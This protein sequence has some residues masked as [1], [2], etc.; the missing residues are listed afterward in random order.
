MQKQFIIVAAT[1]WV[2]LLVVSCGR[3]WDE[4]AHLIDEDIIKTSS[5]LEVPDSLIATPTAMAVLGGDLYWIEDKDDR[6]LRSFDLSSHLAE[7]K[8][9]RKGRADNEL[10]YPHQLLTIPEDHKVGVFDPFL[11]K[12]YLY[13]EDSD[14][15]QP[16]DTVGVAG[17]ASVAHCADGVCG[18]LMQSDKR[19]GVKS[20]GLPAKEFG[21]FDELEIP[22]KSVWSILQGPVVSNGGLMAAFSSYAADYQIIDLEKETVVNGALLEPPVLKMIN[23]AAAM[24]PESKVGF[25]SITCDKDCIYALYDGKTISSYKADSR[26]YGDTIY[27]ISWDGKILGKYLSSSPISVITLDGDKLY[28]SALVDDSYRFGSYKIT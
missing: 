22:A 26:L 11:Q 19:F 24:G 5:F 1:L 6:P 18:V 21:G 15:L 4:K 25:V 2:S 20:R 10:L 14:F 3:T 8:A 9:V 13:S 17:F 16:D 23:G 12:L 27:K 7:V 28:F